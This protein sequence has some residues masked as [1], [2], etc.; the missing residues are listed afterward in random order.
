M[1]EYTIRRYRS[2]GH[3]PSARGTL[4]RLDDNGLITEADPQA[5]AIL[6]YTPLELRGLEAR[7]L[8]AGRDDD[9]L[10]PTHRDKLR[11]GEPVILTLRHK[12]GYFFTA[13]INS[14]R[15]ANRTS[16]ESDTRVRLHDFQQVDPRLLEL[17]ETSSDTGIWE[18]DANLRDVRWSPRI[19]ALLDLRA[20]ATLTPEQAIFYVQGNQQRVRA[21]LRRCLRTGK[22]F[23]IC[24]TL[25]TA[26]QRL[27]QV[28]LSACALREG[29]T[30]HRIAGTVTDL[31][32][33][34]QQQQ[35]EQNLRQMMDSLMAASDE[36]MA[37]V[38]PTMNLISFN[39]AFAH[40][41][42]L[43]FGVTPSLQDNLG[44][45][46]SEHPNERR[47]VLQ[48]WQRAFERDQFMIEMPL[49]HQERELPIFEF[50][51]QR[52]L[53]AQGE[54]LGAI[55][56]A[57]DISH[58]VRGGNNLKYLNT[59]D[60][61][62]G[63]LNRR[64]FLHR[65]TRLVKKPGAHY[66]ALLVLDLDHFDAACEPLGPT[67]S[68]RLLREL[69]S[70]LGLRV[71]QRDALARLSGDKFALLIENCDE[72]TG[73][74]LAEELRE[75]VRQFAFDFEQAT[76]RVTTSGGLLMIEQH[77]DIDPDALLGLAADLCH[78]AKL[79]GRDRIHVGQHNRALE[80]EKLARQHLHALQACLDDHHL[81]L[82]F[83]ALRPVASATWGDH[84]EILARLRLQRDGEEI[85]WQPGEFLPIA[86]RFDLAKQLDRLVIRKTLAWLAQHPLLEPRLKYCGF[87][88]SL[89][90]ALD[91]GFADFVERELENSSFTAERFCFEI[92]ES[93]A[94]QYPDEVALLCDALHEIGCRVALD[95]A[96]ASV[97]SFGLAA[98]LPVD[99][100]KLDQGLMANLHQDSVQQVMV[101][102]LHRIAVAAGKETVATFIEDDDTLRHIRAAG[103]HY[104]QGFR[105]AKPQP[106]DALAPVTLNLQTPA[107]DP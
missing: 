105:L 21:L 8:A 27:R 72:A 17:M 54:L 10:H 43:T 85:L 19:F 107:T 44:D 65:L 69:A 39:P 57:R 104:G 36:L 46:L 83:Q 81:E 41:F 5:E 86:E 56:V 2:D 31:T 33:H 98:R 91:D 79:A 29:D 38:D 64:E 50:R 40:Q 101:E 4:I 11:R 25:I 24:L 74:R 63:L 34:Y 32:A 15:E 3:G 59:H 53:N 97:E 90:S 102:A 49:A 9:P 51:Y 78:S 71:R 18:V 100:I 13:L 89:A 30:I 48:L 42:S 45:L 28:K 20:S 22:G 14:G 95:G 55:Q 93:D 6:G 92:R 60:P 94:T 62:T 87:N 73:R 35:T 66:H 99:V 58:R 77:P 70:A 61:L 88:L 12:D 52:L 1:R 47:L 80:P 68:D 84:V 67:Q 37:A 96:G 75:Q 82:A 23:S 16:L 106:L 7:K 76:Y 26:R 103:L